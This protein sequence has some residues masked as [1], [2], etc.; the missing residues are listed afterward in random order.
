MDIGPRPAIKITAARCYTTQ[1]GFQF[2]GVE[3]VATRL[4]ELAATEA[5]R[6]GAATPARSS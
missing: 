6:V 5:H 4:R 3:H 1:L 2:G